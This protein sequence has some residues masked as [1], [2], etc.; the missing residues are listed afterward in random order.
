ML[1]VDILTRYATALPL[2]DKSARQVTTALKRFV[3]NDRLLGSPVILITDNGLE[4]CN[5]AMTRLLNRHGIK[6][7]FTTPYNPKG[8]G[9]TERLN[10]TLLS[11]L[12]GSLTP[13]VEWDT[14]LPSVLD[15]YNHCPHS[16][17]G[18][19]P[20]EAITGRPSRHP[21]L[22]PD[23]QALLLA[24]AAST[25][26]S[27]TVPHTT[28]VRLRRHHG[29]RNQLE[30]AWAEAEANWLQQLSYHFGALRDTHARTQHQRH[31]LINASR[32]PRAFQAGDLVVLKDIHRP[33]GVEGKLRR[34]YLGPWQV[35]EAHHNN[36]LSLAD[37]DGNLLPRKVPTDHAR[38]WILVNHSSTA[39]MS[40]G[41]ECY[42]TGNTST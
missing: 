11:L 27:R 40:S 3:L 37:L 22:L 15:I 12:R 19:S 5:N 41:G 1:M 8:N 14:I 32:N 28:E 9:T 23:T 2:A 35:V 24:T 20:Y 13:G 31:S 29:T 18:I 17:I 30:E 42:H 6:H 33:L 10:R 26:S 7:T 25:A 38:P 39:S 34:P 4:F 36:T 16:A 21:Q